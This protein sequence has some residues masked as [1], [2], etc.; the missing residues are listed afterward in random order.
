MKRGEIGAEEAHAIVRKARAAVA[1]VEKL[2]S[3]LGSD[4][5]GLPLRKRFQQ[6]VKRIETG[7]GDNAEAR[8]FGELTVAFHELNVR[9]REEFYR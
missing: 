8:V 6:Q 7:T 5:K 4:D 3:R 2:L 9:L 1:R